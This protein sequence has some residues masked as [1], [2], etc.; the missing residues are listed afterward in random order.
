M[1]IIK[2]VGKLL[3]ANEYVLIKDNQCLL[4][5]SGATLE[6][7]IKAVGYKKVVG[8]LLTHG[9]FDHACNCI[10]QAK[11][12]S[13]KIYAS[14]KIKQT[15]TD[16]VAIYSE[17]GSTIDDFSLF[18][19]IDKDKTFA[20]GSFNLKCLY[21]PG[22][23]SCSECYIIDGQLFSGDVLFEKGI[24][25]TD[26]KFSSRQMMYDSLCKLEKQTFESVYSG[27]GESS[28]YLM[29]MKNIALFKRFLSR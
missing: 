15:V 19:F 9:H 25:R 21:T 10:E 13:T 18:E 23:S 8:I 4:V 7:V 29:Q 17:D 12:F 2:L 16:S 5:D 6:E 24:G 22:H 26:L 11:Y 3:E 27:H 20:L 14:S 28:N 1:E